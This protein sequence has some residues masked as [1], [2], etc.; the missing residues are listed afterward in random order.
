M[1]RSHAYPPDLA[2]FVEANWPATKPLSVSSEQ[3][4]EALS[5]AFHASMTTEESRPTRFRLLLTA[6]DQL[7]DA[8]APKQGVLRLKL[9]GYRNLTAHELRRMAPAVPFET[10]LI[11]ACVDDGKLRI[12][13]VAHS[14][15][16]WLAP[17]WGGRGV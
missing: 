6:P 14:G 8:G 17:T 11:G 7:P 3:L 16:A 10:A 4:E 13:G 5:V 1:P 15:P 12:W 2:R 9:D